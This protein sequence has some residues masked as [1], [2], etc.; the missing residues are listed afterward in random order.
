MPD[1]KFKYWTE[2][3]PE[4]HSPF[5]NLYRLSPI[6]LNCSRI[7]YNPLGSKPHKTSLIKGNMHLPVFV[8][9]ISL[10]RAANFSHNWE[11][12]IETCIKSWVWSI[13]LKLFNSHPQWISNHQILKER[14]RTHLKIIPWYHQSFPSEWTSEQLNISWTFFWTKLDS[15]VIKTLERIRFSAN[16]KIGE[17]ESNFGEKNVEEMFNW[18]EVHSEKKYY[19]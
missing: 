2:F 9:I 11:S 18:S 8:R 13:L 14:I 7:L 17:G 16:Q 6:C 10:V 5:T 3:R 12:S 15:P 1:L 4:R 19:L